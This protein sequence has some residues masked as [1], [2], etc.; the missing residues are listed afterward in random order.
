MFPSRIP[1]ACFIVTRPARGTCT[2]P[3]AGILWSGLAVRWFSDRAEPLSPSVWGMSTQP[4]SR[5]ARRGCPDQGRCDCGTRGYRDGCAHV[6]GDVTGSLP[7]NAD[8][9]PHP[10]ETVAHFGT[11]LRALH[12]EINNKKGTPTERKRI[13]KPY[14]ERLHRRA[15]SEE[16]VSCTKSP[17]THKDY[18]HWS[19]S[20]DA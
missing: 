8:R 5:L 3:H 13:S 9:I 20:F 1:H 2:F 11:P 4:A 12:F 19:L 16:S 18:T 15:T 10:Y 6:P 7:N 14:R 17:R